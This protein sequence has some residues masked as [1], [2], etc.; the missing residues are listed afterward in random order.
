[1]K[2][3][4][5]VYLMFFLFLLLLISPLVYQ[6]YVID[7]EVAPLLRALERIKVAT[8]KG[9]ISYNKFSDLL[10]DAQIE[11]NILERKIKKSSKADCLIDVR[12]CLFSYQLTKME[13]MYL[14]ETRYK[15]KNVAVRLRQTWDNCSKNIDS[16]NRCFSESIF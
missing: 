13:W 14:I 7:K 8:Q 2:K 4:L 1:M 16:I 5:I 6:K 3:R 11:Y 10:N 12:D 15:S 9:D